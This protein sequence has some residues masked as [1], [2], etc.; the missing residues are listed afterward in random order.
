MSDFLCPNCGEQEPDI[1]GRCPLCQREL[2]R[3]R[4][5]SER[6]LTGLEREFGEVKA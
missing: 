2:V 5:E 6:V 1:H 4:V 3:V